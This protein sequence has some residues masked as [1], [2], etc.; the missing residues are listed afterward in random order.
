[1]FLVIKI[2]YN[3][4]TYIEEILISIFLYL[5]Q[6][7]FIGSKIPAFWNFDL[8]K[9]VNKQTKQDF[10]ITKF[11]NLKENLQQNLSKL[12]KNFYR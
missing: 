10:Y 1:M 4:R 8:D 5:N 9:L 6:F 3:D 12:F 7:N 11:K 2:K